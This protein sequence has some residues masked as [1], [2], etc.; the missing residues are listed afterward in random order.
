V[1]AWAEL[2]VRH[3]KSAFFSFIALIL[4]STVWGFQS[5]GNLK[6]GGYDDLTSTSSR[7]TELLSKEFDTETPNIILIADMPDYVDSVESKKIGADLTKKVEGYDGV[8]TVTSYYSLGNPPSLRSDDG[9]AVYFFV[10]SD[11]KVSETTLGKHISEEFTGDFESAKIYV[12]GFAAISNSINDQISSDLATAETFAV[13]LTLLLLVF[14]FGSLVAAGLPML[15][16]GLAI[17]GSFFFVWIS[18]LITDT[19]I[20]SVNLITGMGL[21]LGIDYALL[22]VNRFREERAADHSVEQ[23]VI[24]TVNSAGR[25]VLFSGLTVAIVLAAMFFFPQYFL[26]SFA[27]GGVVVVLLAIAGA[28]IA[29]PALLAMLGDKVNAIKFTR[30]SSKAKSKGSW[31]S[32][33][34]FV[35]RRPLPILLVTLIGLGGLMTLMNGVQFGQVDD[36]ILPKTNSAVIANNVIRERFSGREG[37]PVEILVKGA[38]VNDIYDFTEELSKQ[39]H[40]LRVQ[41]ALGISQNGFLDPSYAPAFASYDGDSWQRI[42]AIHDVESRSPAGQ[43]LT[44]AIRAL[45]VDGHQVLVGG[46]AAVYTDSQLGITKQLPSVI[47][48]IVLTTLVLLFL[49]TGSVLLPIKAVVLNIISLGATLGFLTWV[50]VDGNLQWLIGEFQVTGTIDTSSMVLIAIVAFGLSMDYELFLL[51]RIK[52]QHDAGLGTTESVAVGLQ[53]SGRIITTAALVL[54]FS[55][56]A[57]ATSGV[58]IMKMLGIGIAFAILLDATVVRALLVPAL[59]RLFGDLNWWAPKWLKW[60]YRKVGLEH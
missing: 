2:V 44:E 5:F 16:G 26:K 43:K 39:P 13:P 15:V 48:W 53:R 41:S 34:R 4:L 28:L 33:A 8:D 60:V 42:Q 47:L 17:M 9:K 56:V 51:S 23:S 55:F 12:A 18:S 20:F 7:V 54:A 24:R 3:K 52:E 29:L 49:F 19:S 40:I 32:L 21:G 27:L 59:M 6:A 58:S 36:R 31:A 30:I 45:K 35:M 10:K 38:A 57:F 14:V 37:A 25:T 1:N 22:M 46:T 11:G 50:F